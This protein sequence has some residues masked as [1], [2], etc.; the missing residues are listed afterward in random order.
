MHDV[1]FFS[2]FDGNAPYEQPLQFVGKTVPG[3]DGIRVLRN[4]IMQSM[5][6]SNDRVEH[7]NEKWFANLGSYAEE[8]RNYMEEVD[9]VLEAEM[10]LE[11]VFR[12]VRNGEVELREAIRVIK[13]SPNMKARY[14]SAS[15][16]WVHSCKEKYRIRFRPE[17]WVAA[18]VIEKECFDAYMSEAADF[19]EPTRHYLQAV[20]SAYAYLMRQ[21]MRTGQRSSST[22]SRGDGVQDTTLKERMFRQM[23]DLDGSESSNTEASNDT[24]KSENESDTSEEAN[25]DKTNSAPQESILPEVDAVHSEPTPKMRSNKRPRDSASHHR[26]DKSSRSQLFVQRNDNLSTYKDSTLPYAERLRA[27]NALLQS[28]PSTVAKIVPNAVSTC[29]NMEPDNLRHY[30]EAVQHALDA[31]SDLE[32]VWYHLYFNKLPSDL[33]TAIHQH[34]APLPMSLVPFAD[35]ASHVRQTYI[36][37][38]DTLSSGYYPV[39]RILAHKYDHRTLKFLIKWQNCPDE[40]NEWV[41]QS[42]VTEEAKNE[43]KQT[44]EYAACKEKIQQQQAQRALRTPAPRTSLEQSAHTTLRRSAR[45][46]ARV[47]QLTGQPNTDVTGQIFVLRIQTFVAR[48]QDQLNR[49]QLA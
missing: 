6:L 39:E 21:A 12:K 32:P 9:K 8:L 23:S 30:I 13:D 42:R 28:L 47:N 22:R 26:R 38:E 43:Y 41:P 24:E 44:P 45:T 1:A 7:V 14:K 48:L 36:S 5:A 17:A 33:Q 3:T 15:A 34:F 19:T 20:D 31:N 25:K 18:R 40:M 27:C 2:E 37:T 4:S 16:A 46:A 49:D 11:A 29:P 35:V 10:A